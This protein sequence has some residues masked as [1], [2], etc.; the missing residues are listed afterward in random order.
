VRWARTGCA[1][2]RG[3]RVRQR[4]RRAGAAASGGPGMTV[5]EER[6][7]DSAKPRR[8]SGRSVAALKRAGG[9]AEPY[10]S[11][12]AASLASSQIETS[13]GQSRKVR[14]W[15]ASLLAGTRQSTTARESAALRGLVIGI[16]RGATPRN[17]RSV[18]R[19]LPPTPATGGASSRD[20]FVEKDADEVAVDGG[21]LREPSHRL[22]GSSVQAH[23]LAGVC[24]FERRF[25][26]IRRAGARR[27]AGCTR[28]TPGSRRGTPVEARADVGIRGD[29]RAPTPAPKGPHRAPARRTGKVYR[30][31]SAA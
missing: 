17:R 19:V 30:R 12:R 18:R 21:C 26:S 11:V 7:N 22:D 9:E 28:V 2:P 31:R 24:I 10:Q 25:R 8:R 20:G 15:T 29:R 6:R 1:D 14:E 4:Q 3:E 27:A 23:D 16:R 5:P 13:C